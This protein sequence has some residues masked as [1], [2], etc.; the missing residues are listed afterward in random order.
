AY[1]LATA[2]DAIVALPTTVTGGVGV[3]L[4]LY[5][6]H[7]L[8]LQFNII[9]QTVKAGEYIDMGT[10]AQMLPEEVRA[11]FQRMADEYHERFK[12]VVRAARP[13]LEERGGTTFDGRVFGA[14]EALE[15]GLIDRTGYPEDAVAL[16]KELAGV[17]AAELFFYRRPGDPALSAYAV[18]PNVPHPTSGLAVLP[19]IPGLDRSKLPAFLY[20][21]QPEMTLE[22][23]GR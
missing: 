13:N 6:L 14:S 15:R 9:P 16:A 2:A 5:N 21:W 4:N 23:V 11:M 19:S 17:E 8:M 18:T 1:Y 22:R 3:I 20:M 12:E 7:E 10:P